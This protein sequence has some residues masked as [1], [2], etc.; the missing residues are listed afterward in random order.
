M[1][2][3]DRTI[4]DHIMSEPHFW[5]KHNYVL[6]NCFHGKPRQRPSCGPPHSIQSKVTVLTASCSG[7]RPRRK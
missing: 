2:Q 1:S 3:R 5:L 7:L 6:A 4:W